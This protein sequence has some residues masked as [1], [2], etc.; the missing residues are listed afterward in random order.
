MTKQVLSLLLIFSLYSSYAQV[1]D[2]ELWTG[3]GIESK[4]IK[5][6]SAELTIQNRLNNNMSVVKNTYGQFGLDY[7]IS[8]K[9]DA[10]LTY[11]LARKNKLEYYESVHRLCLNANYSYKIKKTGLSFKVRA[12]YQYSFDRFSTINPY[13]LPD[14]KSLYRIKLTTAYKIKS[15]KVIKPFING[16]VFFGLDQDVKHELLTYRLSG[17][18]NVIPNKR[19][20]I[21]VRYIFENNFEDIP[22]VNH[23]YAVTYQ[24]DL[25]GK[26]F[27]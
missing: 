15:L 14:Q 18:I 19:H 16:E 12:R 11:R 1:Q 24:Y 8:S 27:N 7:K 13:I 26:L 4:L 2:A 21:K 9:I 17:G 6:L 25:K 23:I 20:T 5:K 10:G 22:N 3:I